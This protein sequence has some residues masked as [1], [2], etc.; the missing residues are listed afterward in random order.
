[1]FYSM[2]MQK[3][4]SLSTAKLWREVGEGE[5]MIGMLCVSLKAGRKDL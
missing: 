5:V 1:M 3:K 4:E 2:G